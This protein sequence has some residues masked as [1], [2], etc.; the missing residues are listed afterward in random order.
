[1][2]RISRWL[3][4][5][6][7]MMVAYY[8]FANSTLP[9]FV[10]IPFSRSVTLAANS[11]A[12]VL[13]VAQNNTTVNQ[14]VTNVVPS[15]PASSG[16]TGTVIANTCGFLSP[17]SSCAALVKL[18]SGN[19]PTLGNLN[20]SICAFNGAFCSRIVKPI[21]FSNAVPVRIFV[22]PTNPSIATGTTIQFTAIGLFA[23]TTIQDITKSVSWSSSDT[24]K[25]TISN[26]TG[27]EGLA[28]G[29]AAGS[30]VIAATL[31]GVS[32][33]STLSVSGAILTSI[34]V[35]PVNPSVANGEVQ[36]FKATG[37]YSD[38]SN[39]DLTSQVTWSSSS[40][41]VATISNVSGENGLA[42]TK[43]VGTTTI[44]ATF[45]VVS[46]STTLHVTPA[47]LTSISV[48]PANS[49]FTIF[50]TQQFEAT[51][52]Y[53]DNTVKDL[54]NDVTW[55]TQSAL[56][57]IVSNIAGSK[58]EALGVGVGSTNITATLRGVIG[59]TTLQVTQAVLTNIDISPINISLPSGTEQSY[60]A[61]GIYDNGRNQD[62]TTSVIWQS[63]NSSIA[64][65][66]N[67]PDSEG[68]AYGIQ[69][70][71]VVISATADGIV[72]HTH[73]T[74][75]SPTLT[76]ITVTPATPTI[77]V[78]TEEQFTATGNYSDLTTKDLTDQVTWNSSLSSVA[79]IS[80]AEGSEG[81]ASAIA[82]GATTISAAF[83][84][85]SGNTTLTVTSATLLS[86]A[87][88]PANPSIPKGTDQPFTATG[89]Y[90]DA[91]TKDITEEVTWTSSDTS[92]ATISNA[93]LTK[94][95]A[96]AITT[97]STIISAIEGSITG[98]T[99]ASIINVSIGDNLDGGKVACLGGGLNNLITANANNADSI[100]WGGNGTTTNAQS[101]V[102]GEV[103]T[104]KIV[105]IL[106]AG[107]TYAAGV[108]DAYEIDSAGHTPCV[109][110]NTCYNDWFLPAVNQLSC[111]RGNRNQV[112][113]FN[114]DNY[115][116]STE[117]SVQSSTRA[118]FQ[119]F[120]NSGH[121]PETADKTEPYAVRCVR[122]IN[123]GT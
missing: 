75:S 9:G 6:C 55:G 120:Q 103:N 99:L 86:I 81:L 119:T 15:I 115:W 116:S 25:A 37:I 98:S 85:M 16:I 78:G 47:T 7:L 32:G 21:N 28:S 42:T 57:A 58:G 19:Q 73:L 56:V 105:D 13:V 23:N 90:S 110:G 54:T 76:S 101:V 123:A 100:V 31:D 63:S 34:T 62:I 11:T 20:I 111:M 122:I 97:G 30:S 50:T 83:N 2:K 96:T 17:G 59:S 26:A 79:S 66:S 29:V 71:T 18:R 61:T 60:T 38:N 8:S 113:G 106:G 3:L 84:G 117:D 36:Q 14:T 4:A 93:L 114:K 108:C 107:I 33:S 87:V 82:A 43:S 80:N 53:S 46:G 92:K 69:S 1:M 88:T 74:V 77:A 12:N 49:T 118:V 44:I 121:P 27:T 109:G 10:V 40:T 65:I 45:G 5:M 70:G 41:A 72:G 94:G 48:T 91:S 95:L 52:I 112:G 22:T 64:T 35:T 24:S 67:A 51:G 68:L 102:D 39:Q 104:T 89:S